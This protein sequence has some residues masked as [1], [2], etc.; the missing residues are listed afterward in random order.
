MM[1][2]N[3]L[4]RMFSALLALV[5]LLS[6]FPG[7]AFATEHEEP[8]TEDIATATESEALPEEKAPAKSGADYLALLDS[9]HPLVPVNELVDL[10]QYVFLELAEHDRISALEGLFYF[11]TQV[12]EGDEIVYYIM[13]PSSPTIHEKV[14]ATPVQI[15]NN[16]VVGADP[17]MAM[18]LIHDTSATDNNRWEHRIKLRGDY[19]DLEKDYYLTPSLDADSSA[20]C[21]TESKLDFGLALRQGPE[22]AGR[23]S[24]YFY[25]SLSYTGE[26]GET[27]VGACHIRYAT[28]T[29]GNRYFHRAPLPNIFGEGNLFKVYRLLTDRVNVENL[30][31]MLNSIR[32]DLPFNDRYSQETYDEFL[33]VV[34]EAMELYTAYNGRVFSEAEADEKASAQ[35][36]VDSLTSKLMSLRSQL[37]ISKNTGNQGSEIRYVDSTVYRWNETNMNKL[38]MELEDYNLKGFFFTGVNAPGTSKRPYFSQWNAKKAYENLQGPDGKELQATVQ[39][40]G[41]HSGLTKKDL[42]GS[43]D[44][45]DPNIAVSADLWGKESIDGAKSVYTKVG[46]PFVYDIETGYYEM[47]SDKNAVFFGE[48]PESGAKMVIADRPGAYSLNASGFE[49]C[50]DPQTYVYADPTTHKVYDR[51]IAGFQPFSPVTPFE[52]KSFPGD[53]SYTG[54]IDSLTPAYLLDGISWISQAVPDPNPNDFG[55]ATWGFGMMVEF[56]FRMTESGTIIYT[57]ASGASH[58]VPI[59]FEFSGDDDIW[60]YIDNKLAMDIGGTHDAIQ[61]QIDFQTGNVT[62]RSDKFERIIDLHNFYTPNREDTNYT[63]SASGSILGEMYEENIYTGKIGPETAKSASEA[64]LSSLADGEDHVM[65]IYYMDRGKGKT[66]CAIRFNLPKTDILTVEKKIDPHYQGDSSKDSLPTALY[67]NLTKKVYTFTLLENGEPVA[68]MP[69][70]LTRNGSQVGSGVTNGE[71]CFTLRGDQIAEF[72]NMNFAASKTYSV[73]EEELS[74]VYWGTERY[75]YSYS[76]SKIA[77]SASGTGNS[78]AAPGDTGSI[79]TLSFVCTNIYVHTLNL[80]PDPQAVVLDY[81]KPIEVEVVRN[82]VITGASEIWVRQATLLSLSFA[83]NSDSSYGTTTILDKDRNGKNDSFRFTL[84]KML[85]KV[86]TLH[87]KL[88]IPF[89]DGAVH[90][91]ELPVHMIPA[92]QVYYETDFADGV[93]SLHAVGTDNL[94]QSFGT[95]QEELQDEGNADDQ[96]YDF[97]IDRGKIP[98]NAFFTDFDGRGMEERYQKHLL[99]TGYDF[100]QPETYIYTDQRISS[101]RL[102][103]AAGIMEATLGVNSE[104]N[105][106]YYSRYIHTRIPGAANARS[107][108][109]NFVPGANDYLQMRFRLE[110]CEVETG[111]SYFGVALNVLCSDDA[112]SIDIT[113]KTSTVVSLEEQHADLMAGKFVTVTIPLAD[114]QRYTQAA[115]IEAFSFHIEHVMIKAGTTG[116]IYYDYIYVGPITELNGETGQEHEVG[117]DALFFDFKNDASAALRYQGSQYKKS[118]ATPNYDQKE[119]WMARYGSMAGDE[120]QANYSID[121]TN[122]IYKIP[123][124]KAYYTDDNNISRY[125]PYFYMTDSNGKH[126]PFGKEY[127][128]SWRLNYTIPDGKIYFHVRFKISGASFNS[129]NSGDTSPY[130]QC[131]FAGYDAA[132]DP[133]AQHPR[134]VYNKSVI[135]SGDFYDGVIDITKNI[136]D[137]GLV[138]IQSLYVRFL[139]LYQSG[140]T[141]GQVQIDYIYVGPESDPAKV[142]QMQEESVYFGFNNTNTD[143]QRYSGSMYSGINYD[144]ADKWANN[145]WFN[146]ETTGNG[147]MKLTPNKQATHAS[148]YGSVYPLPLDRS[149]LNYTLTGNDHIEMRVRFVNV[150]QFDTKA[151]TA[152]M[153]FGPENEPFTSKNQH[154]HDYGANQKLWTLS[155][156]DV[157][158]GKWITLTFDLAEHAWV[159][160]RPD[161][162]RFLIPAFHQIKIQSGGYIL[163]DYIYL[164]PK[165]DAKPKHESLFFGFENEEIDQARYESDTY[166]NHNYDLLPTAED[167]EGW[168]TDPY[169]HS[170]DRSYTIDNEIGLLT[171]E[172][173]DKLSTEDIRGPYLTTSDLYDQKSNRTANQY[174]VEYIPANAEYMQ[175]RFR[176]NNCEKSENATKDMNVVFLYDGYDKDGKYVDFDT[177]NGETYIRGYYEV[178]DN[179]QVL[180]MPLSEA[181]RDMLMISNFGIRFQHMSSDGGGTV[182]IDY[183]YVGPGELAP[184]PVYGYD[185]S[186]EDTTYPDDVLFFGFGNEEGDRQRYASEIYGGLN[187]DFVDHD[188]KV[189]YWATNG[190]LHEGGNYAAYDI[191]TDSGVLSL[192]VTNKSIPSSGTQGPFLITAPKYKSYSLSGTNATLHYPANSAEVFRIRFRLVNCEK[193]KEVANLRLLV[194]GFASDGKNYIEC[195]LSHPITMTNEYQVIDIYPGTAFQGMEYVSNLGLRFRD[196]ISTTGGHIE[197]D[198][199]YMGP[200]ELAPPKEGEG[201]VAEFSNGSTYFVEG[202]GVKLNDS[203]KTYTEASFNFTGTGFDLISR[204]GMEQATIRVEVQDMAGNR[205]KAITVNNKGDME[206]SQIPVV[207]VH[208]LPHGEYKVFIWVNKAVTTPLPLLNR[209]GQF[210]FDAVRIYDPVDVSKEAGLLTT[211]QKLS[212]DAY[213]NDKEA[214]DYVKE[215][216]DILLSVADFNAVTFGNSTAGALFV[217]SKDLTVPVIPDGVEP[218]PSEPVPTETVDMVTD[219]LA[220]QVRDYN[221]VGPKNEVYLSPGEAV[222][223][224]LMLSAAQKPVSIDIGAKTLLTD[225]G[226]LAAGFVSTPNTSTDALNVLSYIEENLVTSTAMYYDLDINTIPDSK[227][228]YLVIYNAYTGTAK[229]ENI[230]SITDLKVAYKERPTEALPEDD[231]TD[232]GDTEVKPERIRSEALPRR[233]AKVMTEPYSFAV[234]GRTLEAAAVFMNAV[235]EAHK[236]ETPILDQGTKLYHTLNLA[237]DIA[238][239]YLVPKADL[240]SYDTFYLVAEIPT[241]D[242][243]GN[244][245]YRTQTI[246]AVDN[247]GYY[248]YFTLEGLTAVNMNDIILSTL[249]MEKDGIEYFTLTDEYSI[250]SY[251]YAQLNSNGASEKLKALCAE[252]LRYGAAAQSYKGYRTDTLADNAMTDS[253]R[254]YLRNLDEVTFGNNNAI[255]TE[256]TAPSVTW[257]GKALDLNSRVSV[258]YCIDLTNYTGDPADLTMKVTYTD[259]SGQEVT[260][261]LSDPAPYA[262][263]ANC[264]TFLMD[265]LLAA[266][267]RTVLTAQVYAGDTPVSNSLTYSA[268]TYGLNKTGALGSLCKALFAYSDSAKAYFS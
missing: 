170:S 58:E 200:E 227:D 129:Y 201:K 131:T 91:V 167:T 240:E 74:P 53:A 60:V 207:S 230:L 39:Q 43:L 34:Q 203:T 152:M 257:F 2:K 16:R 112:D 263:I 23:E 113:N 176:T 82:A 67:E 94:W 5:M 204:T 258:L 208:G 195:D 10:T 30:L 226:T 147:V 174:T 205:V 11:V 37:R 175:I 173:T 81:G 150:K 109:L 206:L 86:V 47:N 244:V 158:S 72:R 106:T 41:I 133:Q 122:G 26:D 79:E 223:F 111:K 123:V 70:Y 80:D 137:I 156:E 166:S 4:T 264:Y 252:L 222:V 149:A 49:V 234:D 15:V 184:D 40:W 61:G 262:G 38:T 188:K 132:G 116:K 179:F 138:N 71:G 98:S 108:P 228:V 22:D 218:D 190:N 103:A 110:N 64:R 127:V 142:R 139:H 19:D 31:D 198:Y 164:G 216:R 120:A 260:V 114:Y 160:G 161:T 162:I 196:V 46:L 219:H 104:G 146:L 89:E 177:Y 266:E 185:S 211:Q 241:Y 248:Y 33:T 254:S 125:G 9:L 186:Y 143:K 182:D 265:S 243:N 25:R 251:A 95:P 87:A 246:Q 256:L 220:L 101:L 231:N 187:H 8:L 119:R 194:N 232:T 76:G 267:L 136:R 57:D 13:D 6:V 130:I 51:Y 35:A 1:Q 28:D 118:G 168:T 235:I 45:L 135:S 96:L 14:A 134:M 12:T 212:L 221:K 36:Q 44:P 83:N 42:N 126:I 261:V 128:D 253:H 193:A 29:D 27:V 214:H 197:I 215:I 259:T 213:G 189:G 75:T 245:H 181:I 169:L 217:D 77:S 62:L 55:T 237:S 224:K 151:P 183:I 225:K 238:I 249:R 141:L 93:F 48:E 148:G 105:T 115:N 210:Y 63:Y 121:T 99:Y 20:L 209:G 157:E 102:N 233:N 66:N 145:D 90:T 88:E 191:D 73:V 242:K 84:T 68:N 18:E 239:N 56:T 7:Q 59:T 117:A 107:R 229:T 268:D 165:V 92:T 171:L 54:G 50:E 85:D 21:R 97:Y 247:G 69:Y 24:L 180:T 32:E 250:S 155:K 3:R 178:E 202:S 65:R 199:I 159:Q 78:Y 124:G 144:L 192:E 100:D 140:N 17:E 52:W 172:I 153:F 236:A 163:I 154:G 255:G